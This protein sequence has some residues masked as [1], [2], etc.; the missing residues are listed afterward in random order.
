MLHSLT[1][2]SRS[3]NPVFGTALRYTGDRQP[4]RRSGHRPALDGLRGIAGLPVIAVHVGLPDSRDIGVD[5]FFPLSGF[6]VTALLYEEGS[7]TVRSHFV[8]STRAARAGCCWR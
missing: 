1:S 6:L 4:A 2:A 3:T 7:V 8:A 5:V